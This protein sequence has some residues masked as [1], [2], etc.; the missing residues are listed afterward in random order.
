M[1]SSATCSRFCQLCLS[2]EVAKAS[3]EA[4][5]RSCFL[6][7]EVTEVPL[8]TPPA[9]EA[10]KRRWNREAKSRKSISDA[11]TVYR[12][13]YGNEFADE[14]ALMA[15]A[16]P[17]T[18]A[19][20]P[21]NDPEQAENESIPVEDTPAQD[22]EGQVSSLNSIMRSCKWGSS[23]TAVGSENELQ[24]D[25]MQHEMPTCRSSRP[26]LTRTVTFSP[27]PDITSGSETATVDTEEPL[28]Q[29]LEQESCGQ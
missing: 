28:G 17:D 14:V 23:R 12:Q 21:R 24:G 3:K 29:H 27:A 5:Q 8:M 15:R 9:M 16:H 7:P 1:L 20:L 18:S 13:I 19:E 10:W 26:N 4:D 11:F 22:G 6:Y 2:T 25:A